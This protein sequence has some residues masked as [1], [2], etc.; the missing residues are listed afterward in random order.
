MCWAN[1]P[2]D[3]SQDDRQQ[4]YSH[5]A[6]AWSTQSDYLQ[7]HDNSAASY[8]DSSSFSGTYDPGYSSG[9][10]QYS[11]ANYSHDPC[12]LV[13][14]T[15]ADLA[16]VDVPLD[17]NAIYHMPLHGSA[18]PGTTESESPYER[19]RA[20]I[21]QAW[22]QRIRDSWFRRNGISALPTDTQ[23]DRFIP[24]LRA[25]EY[26]E[27]YFGRTGAQLGLAAR[28]VEDLRAVYP[29]TQSTPQHSP[30]S[31]VIDGYSPGGNTSQFTPSTFG[32]H[33]PHESS[34]PMD[35]TFAIP[36]TV[37]SGHVP[38]SQLLQLPYRDPPP[39]SPTDTGSPS[40]LYP[41]AYNSQ[42]STSP[43]TVLSALGS[44]A[45]DSPVSEIHETRATSPAGSA[46]AVNAVAEESTSPKPIAKLDP[47][48]STPVM[49]RSRSV[50]GTSAGQPGIGPARRG[51][52]ASE[53]GKNAAGAIRVHRPAGIK[54]NQRTRC[55]YINPVTG[56]QCRT[57]AGRGPDLERHLRT[58]HL[59]E[60]ARA[61]S[62]G[63][64]PRD[65]A[66]LLPPDWV[67]GDRLDFDCPHC[68]VR[69]TREDARD[70]HVKVQHQK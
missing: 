57:S 34:S 2:A 11:A 58:V 30:S 69:F 65:K 48:T 70:R 20:V 37:T 10:Q 46:S 63:L 66:E 45:A 23:Y 21:R 55:A 52:S 50:E 12:E 47:T 24:E 22:E 68:A 62:D 28:Q 9:S 14:G 29:Q 13:G 7:A 51:N 33:M 18:W 5:G 39:L 4:P 44:E 41:N 1:S 36:S 35:N 8:S 56:L 60:E 42:L 25:G 43:A 54:W 19:D 26:A 15:P 16:W 27:R 38:G 49:T 53:R 40:S 31:T 67:M 3:M 32:N 64:I 6:Y 17:P 61:V 59:R